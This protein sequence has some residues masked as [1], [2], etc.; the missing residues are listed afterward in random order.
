LGSC[1]GRLAYAQ[2]T[3][4]L[5]LVLAG[6][7]AIVSMPS[8]AQAAI[9]I[10][11][12]CTDISQIPQEWL[13]A[14]KQQM[15][16]HYSHES[17]G[18]QIVYGLLGLELI[19]SVKY[20][21]AIRPD[22][23]AQLPPPENPP[24]VRMYDGQPPEWVADAED[25]WNTTSGIN[26]T[27]NVINTLL[28]YGLNVDAW[29]WCW[30]LDTASQQYTQK[31]LNTMAALEAANPAVT[32]VYMTGNAQTSSQSGYNRYLRNEQIRQ[33]CIQNN[34][35][36]FDF[37]DIDAWYDGEQRTYQYAGHTVPLQHSHWAGDYSSSHTNYEGC[38]NKGRAFW[39]L[40]ACLAGWDNPG[41][42][43]RVLDVNVVRGG[44]VMLNPNPPYYLNDEVT[45]TAV[46]WGFWTFE[47]WSG[48]VPPWD[49]DDNPLTVT[50]DDNKSITATFSMLP[51][52]LTTFCI[53]SF[54]RENTGETFGDARNVIGVA[55][56]DRA[57]LGVRGRSS[58]HDGKM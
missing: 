30:Q 12:T 42:E 41:A 35:V 13:D 33:F 21:V 36:L 53:P 57:A 43:R 45:L 18:R 2:V 26:R 7:T 17:H 54:S 48:D 39:W 6:A 56:E 40:M 25:Y 46:P 37:G 51:I 5:G 24:A 28:P 3:C 10:D 19:N 20:S 38:L 14:A 50:M 47:G 15:R 16:I 1:I 11:H 8:L 29:C 34:K 27:Q 55:D 52:D 44:G 9:V 49:E 22:N 31:Y 32:I 58:E 4:V 23:T